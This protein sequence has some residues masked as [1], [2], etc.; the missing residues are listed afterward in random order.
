MAPSQLLNFFFK[1]T[2]FAYYAPPFII[3]VSVYLARGGKDFGD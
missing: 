2:I 1:E 3:R